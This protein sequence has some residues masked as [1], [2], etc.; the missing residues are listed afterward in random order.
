MTTARMPEMIAA[1]N[2][3][4][5]TVVADQGCRRRWRADAGAALAG[6]VPAE[7]LAALYASA[8]I[9]VLASRFEVYGMAFAEA[10]AHGVPLVG[11]PAGAIPPRPRA[12]Q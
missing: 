7:R 6:A 3:P 5:A 9:F 12:L 2:H 11:T 1:L 4:R 8:D 10:I